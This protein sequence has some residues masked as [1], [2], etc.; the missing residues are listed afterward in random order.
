[1]TTEIKSPDE[2][3]IELEEVGL[4][5]ATHEPNRDD[6]CVAAAAQHTKLKQNTLSIFFAIE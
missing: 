2:G 3:S 5:I 6:A 4:N 1:M